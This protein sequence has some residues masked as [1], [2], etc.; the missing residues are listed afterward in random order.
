MYTQSFIF[1]AVA[2]LLAAQ[3][4]AAPIRARQA[5]GCVLPPFLAR[6]APSQ[7]PTA[8]AANIL[9]RSSTNNLPINTPVNVPM[10]LPLNLPVTTVTNTNTSGGGGSAG[11]R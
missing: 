5:P 4:H 3:V 10:G 6:R 8:L 2:V 7:C 9:S 1:S 11:S